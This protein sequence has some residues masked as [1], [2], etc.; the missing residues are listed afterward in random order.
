MG[1][2]RHS[3]K[4]ETDNMNTFLESDLRNT[5]VEC[6][7]WTSQGIEG[8]QSGFSLQE[9]DLTSV[10]VGLFAVWVVF[11]SSQPRIFPLVLCL[12]DR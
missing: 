3:A 7:D 9:K 5:P 2:E 8:L 6:L 10:E 11:V 4:R 1:W 12:A